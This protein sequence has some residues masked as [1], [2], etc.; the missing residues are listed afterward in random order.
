[1][2]SKITVNQDNLRDLEPAP[3]DSGYFSYACCK[4]KEDS[5]D[6]RYFLKKM[7]PTSSSTSVQITTATKLISNQFNILKKIKANHSA[8]LSSVAFYMEQNVMLMGIVMEH[9]EHGNVLEFSLAQS[10]RRQPVSPLLLSLWLRQIAEGFHHLHSV[11]KPPICHGS[12]SSR[13]ILITASLQAKIGGFDSGV[14]GPQPACLDQ[15][16]LAYGLSCFEVFTLACPRRQLSSKQLTSLL[17]NRI[18]ARWPAATQASS[19]ANVAQYVVTDRPPFDRAIE[20]WNGCLPGESVSQLLKMELETT[21]T[22][23][24]VPVPEP[25]EPEFSSTDL[26]PASMTAVNLAKLS[27]SP[28]KLVTPEQLGRLCCCPAVQAVFEPL[29]L[30]LEMLPG[31]LRQLLERGQ[32]RGQPAAGLLYE[33]L[34]LLQPLHCQQLV[35]A[36]QAIGCCQGIAALLGDSA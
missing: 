3:I 36:M 23:S 27:I 24:I 25:A 19:W 30:L 6:Q 22:D 8:L 26:G 4:W 35:R 9:C 28:D 31:E 29:L 1:L 18:R 33:G 34:Q 17:S 5:T 32:A 14:I 11:E 2:S 15:D 16:R 12:F 7:K 10:D 13:N 20:A 21:E